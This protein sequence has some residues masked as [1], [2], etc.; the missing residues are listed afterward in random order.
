MELADFANNDLVK[1]LE[2]RDDL[3]KGNYNDESSTKLINGKPVFGPVK[4]EW[5]IKGL[6]NPH[7]IKRIRAGVYGQ[8][9]PEEPSQKDTEPATQSTKEKELTESNVTPV[10]KND[11]KCKSSTTDSLISLKSQKKSHP[12]AK[13]ETKST[14]TSKKHDH[15]S[16]SDNESNDSD[17]SDSS[18]S[19]PPD[20]VPYSPNEPAIPTSELLELELIA[21]DIDD[22]SDF[23]AG[24]EAFGMDTD[25]DGE[26]EFGEDDDEDEDEF[27]RTRGSLFPSQYTNRIQEE[28]SKLRS[29]GK[30]A[31]ESSNSA[32]ADNDEYTP[33]EEEELHIID[34]PV[35]KEKKRVRFS[36]TIEIKRFEKKPPKKKPANSTGM[37]SPHSRTE[38]IK[39]NS[40]PPPSTESS[41]E[42]K[43]PKVSRFKLE[44]MESGA[45]QKQSVGIPTLGSQPPRPIDS[46]RS[47]ISHTVLE[48]DPIPVVPPSNTR[49]KDTLKNNTVQHTPIQAKQVAPA[50]IDTASFSSSNT[51]AGKQSEASNPH[52][53]GKNGLSRSSSTSKAPAPAQKGHA[54]AASVDL[55]SPTSSR[56]PV[57]S[58]VKEDTSSRPPTAPAPAS[59]KKKMSRFKVQVQESRNPP[60]FPVSNRIEELESYQM[61]TEKEKQ[62]EKA[63]ELKKN[64]VTT[65]RPNVSEMVG[66]IKEKDTVDLDTKKGKGTTEKKPVSKTIDKTFKNKSKPSLK[67]TEDKKETKIP[68]GQFDST[69]SSI[70]PAL[71][72]G[73]RSLFPQS[74]LEKANQYYEDSLMSEEDFIKAHLGDQDETEADAKTTESEDEKKKKKATAK[75]VEKP[76]L[77]ETLVEREVAPDVDGI[78]MGYLPDQHV[79][80][81]KKNKKENSRLGNTSASGQEYLDDYD[82]D[83]EDFSVSRHELLQE[84]Q[85]VRQT[86]IYQTGG[87]GKSPEELEEEPVNEPIKRVSR[88]KMAR[89]S[90]RR[91]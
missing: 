84:Y 4:P 75:E 28:I 38:P 16:S 20:D 30:S 3:L 14:T 53:P 80:T 68:H 50:A 19:Q 27:G 85:K 42:T 29:I 32:I 33:E 18:S 11:E 10:D 62:R 34:A 86:L 66:D 77:T 73:L 57:S 78:G 36:E 74:V 1:A 37:I 56:A 45:S 23:E 21:D 35:T 83:D 60:K 65:A 89:L 71:V 43:P 24:P 13:A 72:K 58:S 39:D 40:T 41:K 61:K 7:N 79:K 67:S 2:G 59:S 52:H 81:L 15:Q 70:N 90:N 64:A 5:L 82:D 17:D 55:K 31:L 51:A 54:K 49:S 8:E 47:V 6:P 91:F 76:I 87:Y 25:G 9:L 69:G 12:T 63:A 26:N 46:S 48:R 22:E 88:F 44:R